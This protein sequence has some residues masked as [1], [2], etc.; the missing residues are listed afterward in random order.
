MAP[1]GKSVRRNQS[2]EPPSPPPS[3]PQTEQISRTCIS[4]YSWK[5]DAKELGSRV[6]QG[7]GTGRAKLKPR[8]G[9][10]SKT[11]EACLKVTGGC[12]AGS[13]TNG[14]GLGPCG[15]YGFKVGLCRV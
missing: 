5:L 11:G 8:T 1:L 10:S 12:V 4:L 13:Y 7:G 9:K 6:G 15:S 3:R 14:R 2:R